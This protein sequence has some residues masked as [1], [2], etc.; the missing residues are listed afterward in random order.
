MSVF[1]PMKLD[2]IFNED[3]QFTEPYQEEVKLA[4][5]RKSE[6]ERKRDKKKKDK[7]K[8]ATEKKGTIEA[9]FQLKE[10]R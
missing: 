7:D 4:K 8:K 9:N 10:K 1:E 5:S 6:V 3:Q 2:E